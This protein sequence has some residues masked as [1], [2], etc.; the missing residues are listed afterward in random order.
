MRPAVKADGSK[1]Y[2]YV[3]SYIY[4]ILVVSER[5]QRIMED[6]EAK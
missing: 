3:L 5:P 2:E 4:D 1:C 6:L